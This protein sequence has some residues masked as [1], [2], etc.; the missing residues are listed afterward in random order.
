MNSVVVWLCGCVGL[1]SVIKRDDYRRLY[2]IVAIIFILRFTQRIAL[3]PRTIIV[4]EMCCRLP[5]LRLSLLSCHCHLLLLLSDFQLFYD[6]LK[7]AKLQTHI[8]HQRQ[9]QQHF[10]FSGRNSMLFEFYFYDRGH[11]H[12]K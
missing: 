5:D 8:V 12:R 6:F 3:H 2:F 7:T 1:S 4:L 11:G 9:Q 10:L